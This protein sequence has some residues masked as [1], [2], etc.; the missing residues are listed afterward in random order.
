MYTSFPSVRDIYI[1]SVR[2][3]YTLPP[4]FQTKR[5]D[6]FSLLSLV[7]NLWKTLWKTCGKHSL[8][9]ACEG[10]WGHWRGK[11]YYTPPEN[12]ILDKRFICIVM[13]GIM[14]VWS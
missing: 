12:F 4:I 9:N 8:K 2:D 11:V 7:N 14:Y 10:V 1:P 13:C 3:I 6:G 5:E